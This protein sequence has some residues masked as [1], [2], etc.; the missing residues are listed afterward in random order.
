MYFSDLA[1][2]FTSNRPKLMEKLNVIASLN[3]GWQG[4]QIS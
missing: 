2:P 1:S 3:A 4:W